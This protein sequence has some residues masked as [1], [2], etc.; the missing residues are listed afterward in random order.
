MNTALDIHRNEDEWQL[1]YE[2]D[3]L[4]TS[5]V[6]DQSDSGVKELGQFIQ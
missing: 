2:M 5:E 4:L 1:L 3:C 6:I